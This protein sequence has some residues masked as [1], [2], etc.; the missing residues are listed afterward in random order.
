MAKKASDDQA[1]ESKPAKKTTPRKSSK[2]ATKKTTEARETAAKAAITSIAATA[3]ATTA[4]KAEKKTPKSSKT[5]SPVTHAAPRQGNGKK[6]QTTPVA[7][8]AP[9]ASTVTQE[10]KAPQQRQHPVIQVRRESF[11]PKQ[12]EPRNDDSSPNEGFSQPETVGGGES[13]SGNNNRNKRRNRNRNN[14]RQNDERQDEQRPLDPVPGTNRKLDL[15]KLAKYAWK[16]FLAEVTEEGLALMDDSTTRETAK[17]A[18]RVAEFFINEESRRKHPNDQPRPARPN[19]PQT[20]EASA[21]KA[22]K[23]VSEDQPSSEEN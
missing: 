16:I 6:E 22:N 10:Q 9:P 2:P 19:Q 20:P 18:F 21:D 11:R 17:R 1:P 14:R 13:F 4:P 7:S 12:Q 5:K 23:E 15:D 3:P 8:V